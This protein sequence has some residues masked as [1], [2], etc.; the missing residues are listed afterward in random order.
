MYIIYTYTYVCMM[1]NV[2]DHIISFDQNL[3]LA[4]EQIIWIVSDFESASFHGQSTCIH[5]DM[6]IF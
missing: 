5:I 2:Y 4:A 1:C 3:P 6:H